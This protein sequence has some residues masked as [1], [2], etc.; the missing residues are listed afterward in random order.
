MNFKKLCLVL[1]LLVVGIIHQ[2]NA[3]QWKKTDPLGRPTYVEGEVLV[4]F[5]KGAS[6]H[7]IQSTHQKLGANV[8]STFFATHKK[9]A[10]IYRIKIKQGQSVEEAVNEYKSDPQVKYAEPNFIYYLQA[11]PNDTHYNKL[12]GLHNTGQIVNFVSGTTDADIDATE[13]WNI[14]TGSSSVIVAVI[15]DGVNGGHS[16]LTDNMWINTAE[17]LGV[18]GVDDDKNGY[19]DDVVGWDFSESDNSPLNTDNHGTHIA[20]TIG[21]K[22]NNNNGI[23]GINWNIRVMAL[24]CA[25]TGGGLSDNAIISAINYAV[26]NGAKVINASFGGPSFSQFHYDAI[27]AAGDDGVIFVAAACNSANNNDVTPTYPASYDLDNIISVAATDQNDNLASFSNYG[28]TTVDVAA[29]GVDIFSTVYHHAGFS[30]TLISA[31]FGSDAAGRSDTVGIRPRG[32]STGGTNNTWAVS[33]STFTSWPN[34]IEDSPAVDYQ[35]NTNSFIW[36]ASSM[37]YIVGSTYTITFKMRYALESGFDFLRV[38][39]A[40]HTGETG[41]FVSTITGSSGGI[42]KNFSINI[43]TQVE[44]LGKDFVFGFSLYSDVSFPYEGVYIDDVV[45]TRISPTSVSTYDPWPG[46][47]MAAP[48][49]SGIAGLIL[50]YRPY[51]TL[52]ELK[53]YLMSGVDEKS[54]LTNKMVT[55]GRVNAYNSLKLLQDNSPSLV[56]PVNGDTIYASKP[57]TF[58]WSA[59]S[60]AVS[61]QIMVSSRSDF[62]NSIINV[63]S[64]TSA[65]YTSNVG[66]TSGIYYWRIRGF[67]SGG[68]PLIWSAAHTFSIVAP[69][70]V[71]DIRVFPNPFKDGD[72]KYGRENGIVFD[73]LP[74]EVRIEIYNIAGELVFEHAKNNTNNRYDWKTVN[75]NGNKVASGVYVYV[76]TSESTKEKNKGKLSIIR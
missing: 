44:K 54:S 31:S 57:P 34:C 36:C 28:A 37:S 72:T 38:F 13:A 19:I 14:T 12:W 42:F 24:K 60:G 11:T 23:T 62:T 48:H 74:Q 21:A 49:V 25:Q 8:I 9:D 30:Y 1:T 35:N 45:L 41:I 26:L 22:G 58:R 10:I 40:D 70:S 69:L 15:D 29:P 18:S 59:I 68:N 67:K 27:K 32:W 6:S 73:N 75:R 63:S 65:E 7:Q 43:S 16:D 51:L 61:Y 5:K 4:K 20:G 17:A 71:S 33:D 47:S 52:S 66:L 3:E 46:T 2:L 39:I 55:G 50:A 76:V 53:Q 56:S 64:I